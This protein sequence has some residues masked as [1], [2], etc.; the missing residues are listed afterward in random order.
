[1]LAQRLRFAMRAVAAFFLLLLTGEAVSAMQA[2]VPLWRVA[3]E[4]RTGIGDGP[5]AL[6][7]V[8]DLTM[9]RDG[10]VYVSQ[11]Q[12]NVVK[13]YDAQGRYLRSI[14]R[15]GGGPGEFERPS[16]LGWRGDTLWVADP[17]QTR[18]SLFRQDGTFVRAI[19]FSRA[20][21]VTNGRHHI[22][23]S[24]LAD[25]SVLGFWQAPLFHI[26]GPRPVT[27]PMVRFTSRGDPIGLLA[28][29]E[30][31]NEFGVIEEGTSRTYF[32]QPF[33]DSPLI[34]VA[35]DG[36]GVVIVRR[37]AA[38]RP[39]S[40]VFSV[41]GIDPSGRV[42]LARNYRYKPVPLSADAVE[43][44]VERQIG[45]LAASRIRTP[46]AA[47]VS[48]QT[49]E[50]LYRPRFLPPVTRVVVGRDGTIWLRR[51]DLGR[52][53]AWW[54]VLDSRG[55]IIA[56]AWVPANLRV[57]Y[58]DRTHIWGVELDELDVP[59]LV[60]YRIVAAVA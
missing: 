54:H 10:S 30:H 50:K 49:R 46:E 14:G 9:A 41:Q 26:A 45:G 58:A 38:A 8:S 16:A 57:E 43:R 21:P 3:R 27:V 31:R 17:P 2:Q 51:E 15:E 6:S 23:G 56:R 13:V 11:P 36:S 35:P 55:R 28:L 18:I 20:A 1:M 32:P 25:G 60:K 37:N 47:V 24:L 19:S 39:D 53:M 40:T 44:A 59:T 22:P 33:T 29:R 12:E 7:A 48:R 34:A 42:S 52:D 4:V 5:G